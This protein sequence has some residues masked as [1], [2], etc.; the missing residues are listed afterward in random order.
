V[1]VSGWVVFGR[2]VAALVATVVVWSAGMAVLHPAGLRLSAVA[3]TVVFAILGPA[4]AAL[5]AGPGRTPRLATAIPLVVLG[6]M[7]A[8]AA[9]TDIWAIDERYE[10]DLDRIDLAEAGFSGGSRS[11]DGNNVCVDVCTAISEYYG[12]DGDLAEA[13]VALRR[14]ASAAG[15]NLRAPERGD[16]SARFTLTGADHPLDAFLTERSGTS[17]LTLSA[18]RD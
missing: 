3:V 5:V 1:K 9:M 11:Q 12:Y 17:A 7:C 6:L 18:G 2:V 10:R 4:V 15:M 14:A 13:E 8:W 16:R